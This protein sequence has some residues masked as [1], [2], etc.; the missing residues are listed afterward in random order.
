MQRGR[1]VS[2]ER[3]T[4]RLAESPYTQQ[5]GDAGTAG[6]VGLQ[7]IYRSSLQHTLEIKEI[8]AIFT[9]GN[10]H[11]RRSAVP[12]EAQAFQIVRRYRLLEP[13]HSKL[14]EFFG[15]GQRLLAAV[16]AV[17]VNKKLRLVA[18][19]LAQPALF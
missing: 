1:G 4:M 14:G 7:H 12:Q 11:L 16:S 3:Q 2:R 10:F 8:V 17:G 13:A 19:C 5:A 9:G 15:L 6:G 18:D